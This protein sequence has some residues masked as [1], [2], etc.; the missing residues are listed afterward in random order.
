[1][2]ARKC[3]I[4]ATWRRS[5]VFAILLGG[6]V[7]CGEIPTPVEPTAVAVS[8]LLSE[9]PD[10]VYNRWIVLFR[11]DVA[12]PPALAQTLL[13]AHG[14]HAMHFYTLAVKGFAVA[15]LSSAAVTALRAN[16]AVRLVEESIEVPH[17]AV[18][19][20]PLDSYSYQTSSLWSL[21]RMHVRPLTFD[22][23]FIYD[24]TGSGVHI[25]VLDTGI[26]CTHQEFAG[27]IGECVTRPF[28]PGV[29]TLVSTRTDM[30]RP[31]L[32]PQRAAHTESRRRP[33]CIRFG[34]TTTMKHTATTS[35]PGST[36][37]LETRSGRPLP[38]SRAKLLLGDGGD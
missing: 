24:Y 27:R 8:Q 31:W 22:G 15:N 18:Q 35:L 10:S 26:R 7:A 21:D 2:C 6:A 23:Q 25:Y 34:S 13:R 33:S 36:G 5:Q 9:R 37:S 20:L 11:N 19:Q 12:D 16:P 3:R 14:G 29:R 1:M 38:T 30:E 17:T 28:C 4:P 32:L